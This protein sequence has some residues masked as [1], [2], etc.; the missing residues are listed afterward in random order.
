MGEI[1]RG[2]RKGP[3]EVRKRVRAESQMVINSHYRA[4]AGIKIVE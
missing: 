2:A 4:K 3:R 1:C